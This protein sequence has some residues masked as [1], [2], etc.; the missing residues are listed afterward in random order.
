MGCQDRTTSSLTGVC[1]RSIEGIEIELSGIKIGRRR[2]E[3][4]QRRW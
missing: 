3:E 1:E 4:E 2:C